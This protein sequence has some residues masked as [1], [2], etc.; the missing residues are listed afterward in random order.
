MIDTLLPGDLL[1]GAFWGDISIVCAVGH[2][3]GLYSHKRR[4]VIIVGDG[5]INV[6]AL[7]DDIMRIIAEKVVV[8]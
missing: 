2:K 8:R 3:H 5:R 7:D 1:V 4:E 6:A